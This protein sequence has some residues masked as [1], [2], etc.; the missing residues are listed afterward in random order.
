MKSAVSVSWTAAWVAPRSSASAGTRW[1]S[2]PT[3]SR[4]GTFDPA[5]ASAPGPRLMTVQGSGPD[6]SDEPAVPREPSQ[7]RSTPDRSIG[8]IGKT[9]HRHPVAADARPWMTES[10]GLLAGC[11]RDRPVGSS[12]YRGP[13]DLARWV[14]DPSRYPARPKTSSLAGDDATTVPGMSTTLTQRALRP[15]DAAAISSTRGWG[16]GPPWAPIG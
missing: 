8:I 12:R 4:S 6:H 1:K 3:D 9:H 15:D 10:R 13:A 2:R 16:T 5:A 11:G 7:R 14:I